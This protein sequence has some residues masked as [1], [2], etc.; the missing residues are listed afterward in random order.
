[1]PSRTENDLNRIVDAQQIV[2]TAVGGKRTCAVHV[3]SHDIAVTVFLTRVIRSEKCGDAAAFDQ[4]GSG[5][6]R[7]QKVIHLWR[8]ITRALLVA[9]GLNVVDLDRNVAAIVA[10]CDKYTIPVASRP[11]SLITTYLPIFSGILR[12]GRLGGCW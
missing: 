2:R 8:D 10:S 11:T 5:P 3:L 9:T 4:V 12:A 7:I 1:M 6:L